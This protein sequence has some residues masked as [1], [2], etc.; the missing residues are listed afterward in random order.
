MQSRLYKP[1]PKLK[2]QA[3]FKDNDL[4]AVS[5]TA[6]QTEVVNNRCGGVFKT[7]SNT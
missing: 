1:F 6:G 7:L 5:A 3:L 2:R 4:I